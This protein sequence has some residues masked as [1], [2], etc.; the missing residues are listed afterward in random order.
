MSQNL[1]EKLTKC[2]VDTFLFLEISNEELVN[3]DAAVAM[4]EQLSS[5]I[6]SLD[7]F[8]K[9]NLEREIIKLSSNYPQDVSDIIRNMP[10]N[11]GIN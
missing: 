10:K 11:L 8:N 7:D 5:D 6:Q 4:L 1:I 2:L 3:E 9:K